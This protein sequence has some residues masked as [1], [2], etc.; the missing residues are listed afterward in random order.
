[1]VDLGSL[2]SICCASR[3]PVLWDAGCEGNGLSCRRHAFARCERV[4]LSVARRSLGAHPGNAKLLLVALPKCFRSVSH[5]DYCI[6]C[7]K[8]PCHIRRNFQ[9]CKVGPKNTKRL[10]VR[11]TPTSHV[12]ASREQ[13]RHVY[14]LV[15]PLSEIEHSNHNHV[16][17]WPPS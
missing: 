16:D 1:M 13:K 15:K 5:H 3:M 11:W 12:L 9:L 10:R 8:F 4:P 14:T 17:C 2:D 6:G 7:I